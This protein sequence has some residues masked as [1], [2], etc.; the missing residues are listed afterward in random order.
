MAKLKVLT[1]VGTRPEI[2]RLSEVIRR[3]ESH[4]DHV[5]VHTGQNYDYELNEVFFEDLGLR[6]PDHFLNSGSATLGETLGKI[7]SGI[8]TVLEQESPDA[9]LVLGD[10]NSSIAAII[11]KRKKIPIFHMEAGNRCFDMNVPE[12]I[13]RRIID[14]ISDVNLPY[15]EN[16]RHY[17]LQEGVAR[18]R[19]F[20][21]GSP[22][23][24]VLHAQM[25]KIEASSALRELGLTR[26]EYFLV[27]MHREENVDSPRN[28]G[29]LLEALN[30]VARKFAQP[31]IVSTHPRTRKR[32][33]GTR[34]KMEPIIR[35]CKPFGFTDYVHLQM[36]AR[37][38]V[39][40][41]GT[42]SEE[43][44]ILG[45]PAVT[46]REA[47]ERPEALDT[48]AIIMTGLNGEH[49][50]A[51]MGVAM[52]SPQVECPADYLVSNTSERVLKIILGY[53]QYVNK[54]VWYKG[55]NSEKA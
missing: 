39:S 20:V 43:S 54:R 26:G 15:S 37:C 48:G 9:F 28:L 22:M 23:R 30:A 50:L 34:L 46:V 25:A 24:E 19:I 11:A 41:S 13:N 55:F 16:A 4:V 6:R 52:S 3:L 32:L 1:V 35:F 7:L 2:I 17:L 14:H 51:C 27:S 45:F 49:I 29:A 33:E 47:I 31:V 21:T 53:V 18:D 10:T 44:S 40:D 12:E 36:N 42:I 8:E 38:V 5:L